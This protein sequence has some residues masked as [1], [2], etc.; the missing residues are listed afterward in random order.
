MTWRSRIVGLSEEPPDQLLANPSNPRRHPGRQREVMRAVLNDL[1]FVAPVIVNDNTGYM[2]DGHLRCEE[3]L[4]EGARTIP[5][6]HVE[7]SRQE[8]LEAIATLDP[9]SAMARYDVDRLDELMAD[10]EIESPAINEML[11]DLV[12]SAVTVDD[13]QVAALASEV[14]DVKTLVLVLNAEQWDELMGALRDVPGL[15]SAEKIL[16]IARNYEGEDD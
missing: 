3:A 1:G 15:T 7:L 12:K 5:V 10:V 13:A 16:H 14:L 4:S 8:E 11:A 2:I 9:I 6:I